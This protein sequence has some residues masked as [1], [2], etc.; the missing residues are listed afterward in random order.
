V[1][2]SQKKQSRKLNDEIALRQA[3]GRCH[4]LQLAL[5]KVP[6]GRHSARGG[7]L[8]GRQACIT[9]LPDR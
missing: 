2:E 9:P 1:H 3:I 5:P 8:C 4:G 7:P 6:A